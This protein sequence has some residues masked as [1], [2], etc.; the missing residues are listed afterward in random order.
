MDDCCGVVVIVLGSKVGGFNPIARLEHCCQSRSNSASEAPGLLHST[1]CEP[2]ASSVVRITEAIGNK[3]QNLAAIGRAVDGNIDRSSQ[4]ILCFV[5]TNGGHS[6][7][8]ANLL[9]SKTSYTIPRLQAGCHERVETFL[10]R[11]IITKLVLP[12]SRSFKERNYCY[13]NAYLA[14]LRR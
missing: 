2:H 7:P 4:L 1:R 8:T 6:P 11:P 12:A 9:F 3:S 13:Q 14:F 10:P 5:H